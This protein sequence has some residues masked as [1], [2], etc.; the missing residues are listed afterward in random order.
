MCSDRS[1]IA[2]V[3]IAEDDWSYTVRAIELGI[4]RLAH[5]SAELAAAGRADWVSVAADRFR[6]TIVRDSRAVAGVSRRVEALADQ[7]AGVRALM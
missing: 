7:W 2:S 6:G 3:V 1:G 4:A 5:A